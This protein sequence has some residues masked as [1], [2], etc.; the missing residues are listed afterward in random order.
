[1]ADFTRLPEPSRDDDVARVLR[2]R[3]STKTFSADPLDL[4]SISAVLFATGGSVSGRRLIPSAR[5]TDPVHL[6]LVAGDVDGLATG[7]YL[8]VAESHALQMVS[9]AD[10]RHWIAGA[11]LDAPWVA[12]CPGLI[13][14]SADLVAARRRFPDQPAEHGERFVWIETGHAAQNAYLT[15]ANQGLGTVLIAG[16]D[17]DRAEETTSGVIPEGHR[18][19][20]VLPLGFAGEMS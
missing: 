19:L 2:A 3:R 14:L 10:V 4:T 5:A 6:T 15:A 11:T 7:V 13:L 8:Y 9:D 1:M 16:L 18:L 20:G 17:D 12:T